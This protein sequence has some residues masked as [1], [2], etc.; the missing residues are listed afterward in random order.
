MTEDQI[1]DETYSLIYR[2]LKHPIRR[3]ILRMVESHELSFSEILE[4]LQ[5]DSGHLSYHL[6]NLGDLITHSPDGK[7]KLSRFGAASV[8]L[9][10]GVEDK[11]KTSKNKMA[12]FTKAFSVGLAI[13][14][15][16]VSFYAVA[17][18]SSY[19]ST[20]TD[21]NKL[22]FDLAPGQ[23]F[24]CPLNFTNAVPYENTG[25]R[26]LFLNASAVPSPLLIR[27]QTLG[28]VTTA[29]VGA[30][31]AD[32]DYGN[33]LDVLTRYHLSADVYSNKTGYPLQLQI[34][35]TTGKQLYSTQ[36]M[37]SFSM[38]LNV[39]LGAVPHLG[40][41]QIQVTNIGAEPVNASLQMSV[42]REQVQKP[43]FYYGVAGLA[44]AAAYIAVVLATIFPKT[45]HVTQGFRGKL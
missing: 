17:F 15:V 29:G 27:P 2:S 32:S 14:L 42:W 7:Y 9:M 21:P 28:F 16:V 44:A 20:F 37:A 22:A 5:I 13:V 33:G 40:V 30:T 18:A 19:Q 26:G 10:E 3:K 35:D 39:G 45:I 38:M 31:F 43:L 8:K 34:Y 25:Y 24:S 1:D 36:Y 23:T 11:P 6:E 4:A 12:V 41:Y